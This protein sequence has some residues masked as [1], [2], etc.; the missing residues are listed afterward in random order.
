LGEEEKKRNKV[1]IISLLII[2]I[3]FVST[4]NYLTN[5]VN[6]QL[7]KYSDPLN[8]NLYR[9][10]NKKSISLI[11]KN[12]FD[13]INEVNTIIKKEYKF[14]FIKIINQKKEIGIVSEIL[15]KIKT[16]KVRLKSAPNITG[17]EIK[18]T[19]DDILDDLELKLLYRREFEN[20]K[21]IDKYVEELRFF[22]RI[23]KTESIPKTEPKVIQP[24]KNKPFE[25][26]PEREKIINQPTR[27]PN[28][29]EKLKSK[30]IVKKKESVTV[31]PVKQ[32]RKINIPE[33][34]DD[35]QKETLTIPFENLNNFIGKKVRLIYK[36]GRVQEGTLLAVERNFL[37]IHV[38]FKGGNM[39]MK[40]SF[41]IIERVEKVIEK[42]SFYL[43][44]FRGN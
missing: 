15:E 44:D 25:K 43:E 36:M 14:F 39:K 26:K 12:F 31:L 40:I 9:Y 32:N 13:F 22:K 20:N 33:K 10:L 11:K 41:N 3:L 18:K 42:N 28:I 5:G 24:K 6:T 8:D 23:K 17:Q 29:S 16:F 27:K 19:I 30:E 38:F 1:T 7:I 2:I 34:S 35:L 37:N 4:W 21:S